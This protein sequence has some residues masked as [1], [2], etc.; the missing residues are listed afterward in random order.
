MSLRERINQL[1]DGT[2]SEQELKDSILL[3]VSIWLDEGADENYF[4]GL[5]SATGLRDMSRLAIR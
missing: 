1:F 2:R 5:P 3:T 4:L